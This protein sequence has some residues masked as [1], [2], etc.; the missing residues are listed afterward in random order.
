MS[1]SWASVL[2]TRLTDFGREFD[3]PG[4]PVSIKIRS[5]LQTCFCPGCCPEAFARI[6]AYAKSHRLVRG[7]LQHHESGPEILAWAAV[8]TLGLS[9]AKS[10]VELITA[11]VKD[12]A[13]YCTSSF[14]VAPTSGNRR[15][16]AS[17]RPRHL[18]GAS[19]PTGS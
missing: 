3:V 13:P 2:R 6:N 11:I 19:A 18:T 12:S 10:V 14:Q 1:D 9:L 4:Q 7:R 17:S 8:T 15:R 5:T 16:L